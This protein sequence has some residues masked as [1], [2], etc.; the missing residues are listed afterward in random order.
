MGAARIACTRMFLSRQRSG[1]AVKTARPHRS[2]ASSPPRG[3]KRATCRLA[4]RAR[5]A[6]RGY[7]VQSPPCIWWTRTFC[8]W[9]RRAVGKDWLDARSDE[10]F[11]S[12]ITVDEVGDGIARLRRADRLDDWFI[13][14]VA[15][16]LAQ[17]VR[18]RRHENG[19][20]ENGTAL[21][22][23]LASRCPSAT[24]SASSGSEGCPRFSLFIGLW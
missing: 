24:P 13:A 3:S 2:T 4:T 1:V 23:R 18:R 12:T 17:T 8:R 6:K 22:N 9:D 11:L 21:R 15:Y 5:Y 14:V 16:Q 10:L 7:R 20:T 19:H